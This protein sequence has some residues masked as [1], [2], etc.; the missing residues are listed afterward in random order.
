MF[1]NFRKHLEKIKLFNDIYEKKFEFKDNTIKNEFSLAYFIPKQNQLNIL[2]SSSIDIEQLN[3]LYDRIKLI[4]GDTQK[5]DQLLLKEEKEANESD[6]NELEDD[7]SKDE[8]A[9]LQ[10]KER[11]LN[12]FITLSN[13][14]FDSYI[15]R[16]DLEFSVIFFWLPWQTSS[17]I[18][19]QS[20]L[21]LKEMWTNEMN[22][23]N[24]QNFAQ[25]NCFDHSTF[26]SSR[27]EIEAFP[28]VRFYQNGQLLKSFNGHLPPIDKIIK[29]L[30]L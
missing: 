4:S 3:L 11:F 24:V 6:D 25:I 18:S 15:K 17:L 30:K 7:D 14:C 29:L 16:T 21:N 8:I 23:K 27:L 9:L 22:L 19:I 5:Y 10:I 28:S 20:Y 13:H 2:K 26:C 12:D 1:F